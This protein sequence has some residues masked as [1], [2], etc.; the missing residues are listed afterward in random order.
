MDLLRPFSKHDWKTFAGAEEFCPGTDPLIAYTK[1][2]DWP[3]QLGLRDAVMIVDRNSI[4]LIDTAQMHGFILPHPP[5]LALT[6]YGHAIQAGY[7]TLL[8]A[9]WSLRALEIAGWE[10]LNWEHNPFDPLAGAAMLDVTVA[11]AYE[12]TVEAR[13]DFQI[14]ATLKQQ[15]AVSDYL[16]GLKHAHSHAGAKF[17]AAIVAAIN[18]E[19]PQPHQISLQD[20]D[21]VYVNDTEFK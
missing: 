17:R 1:V 8:A 4:Q 7:Q 5:E 20:V 2:R 16:L 19:L 18:K 10:P 6:T 9:P 21:A 14:P 11:V 3:P 13:L 15:T 12:L